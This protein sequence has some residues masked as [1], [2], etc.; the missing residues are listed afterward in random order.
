MRR[1]QPWLLWLA[2]ALLV[3]LGAMAVLQYRWVGEVSQAGRQRLTTTLHTRAQQFTDEFDQEIA[4][5]FFWLQVEPG[6]L[7]R[8][9][10]SRYTERYERWLAGAAHPR[11]VRD[12]WLFAPGHD[13]RRFDPGARSF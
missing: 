8:E 3:M 9:D 4:R 7:Q 5:A 12:I 11:L 13:A 10:W 2:L 6:A 1:R